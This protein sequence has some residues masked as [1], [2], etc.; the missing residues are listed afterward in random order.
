MKIPYEETKTNEKYQAIGK[1]FQVDLR[2]KENIKVLIDINIDSEVR[3]ERQLLPDS[4]RSLYSS[5]L[6]FK[7]YPLNRG[8]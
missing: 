4:N 8:F 6:E 5:T 3:S 2:D 1:V 7:L